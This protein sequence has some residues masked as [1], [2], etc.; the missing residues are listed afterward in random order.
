M[1]LKELVL[2]IVA[3]RKGTIRLQRRAAGTS[4]RP[5][6]ESWRKLLL[7]FAPSLRPKYNQRLGLPAP[8]LGRM[9]SNER[10]LPLYD[11]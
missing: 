3:L 5:L 7:V 10:N 9:A 11:Y 4:P 1:N 6:G 8:L 2:C